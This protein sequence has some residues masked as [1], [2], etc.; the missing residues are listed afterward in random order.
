MM[1]RILCGLLAVLAF[2][3][4]AL[5]YNDPDPLRWIVLYGLVG[6]SLLLT[7]G[8]W[9]QRWLALG[10]ALLALAAAAWTAPGA[11]KFLFNEDGITLADGMSNLHPYIE[12]GREFGGAMLALGFAVISGWPRQACRHRSP[13]PGS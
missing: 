13:V 10:S 8:G 1:H 9:Q 12:Q 4:A 3:S 6:I 11:W 5:Q 2:S 7:A